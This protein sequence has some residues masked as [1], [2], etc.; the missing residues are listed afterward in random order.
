M[1]KLHR[2]IRRSSA[3]LLGLVFFASGIVKLID[4]VGAG[5]VMSEYFKFFNLAFLS[6]LAKASGTAMAFM[7]TVIGAGLISGVWRKF[8]AW[9][10]M[11]VTLFFTFLTL[12][13]YIKNPVMDCGCFGEAIHLTHLQTFLKNIVLLLLCLLAFAPFKS[14]GPVRKIKYY[15]FGSVVLLM[16]FLTVISLRDIPSVDF[17]D[18]KPGAELQ[19]AA[20]YSH[21]EG[22]DMDESHP[23][24]S[25][26]DSDW[27]YCDEDAVQGNV[28]AISVYDPVKIADWSAISSRMMEAEMAG[29][30]P[31]LLV[32]G[33]PDMVSSALQAGMSEWEADA[34]ME[35]V[36]F[37]DYKT[38]LTL[39][40]SNGGATYISDG[41]IVAKW[42]ARAFPEQEELEKV[43]ES[44]PV[45]VMLKRSNRGR[46]LL[47]GIALY[48]L[49]AM[50]LL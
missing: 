23:V 19:A 6:P 41:V 17:T 38:L 48:S 46:L 36:R 39:N 50:L 42:S 7:E 29:F 33:T 26:L 22:E 35:N 5:L 4:P 34:I 9:L 16:A 44:N 28:M 27:N 13:L 20:D 47:E 24:L 10:T 12:L 40:R 45:E 49:G 25:L 32:S 31:M 11:A 43:A 15:A 37:A 18:Y 21:D 14:F 8:F 30:A 3:I 1:K 2:I